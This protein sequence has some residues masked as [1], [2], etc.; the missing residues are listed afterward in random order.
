M[1]RTLISVAPLCAAAILMLSCN[2]N[3]SIPSR[4]AHR[5]A[6]PPPPPVPEQALAAAAAGTS[7]LAVPVSA[8]AAK[9]ARR[10]Y[11]ERCAS[12]HGFGGKGDGP[13]AYAIK[14]KPRDYTD[15]EWQQTIT[16]EELRK[17]IAY[18]GAS[19]GKS[20]MMPAS[21]DLRSKPEIISALVALVRTFG[22][23]GR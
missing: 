22:A 2:S 23:S 6:P 18:G 10:A 13:G 20:F 1:R 9:A 7:A 5:P 4:R 19:V 15:A 14:P 21:A 17:A 16:D 12:C 11:D 3:R 8:D